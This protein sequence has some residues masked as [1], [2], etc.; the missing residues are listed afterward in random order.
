MI[1]TN[2]DGTGELAPLGG[3]FVR[4]E[5]SLVSTQQPLGRYT[6]CTFANTVSLS[7]FNTIGGT[8]FAKRN[9]FGIGEKVSGR[10]GKEDARM[11]TTTKMKNVMG[12]ITCFQ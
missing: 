5:A 8:H 3:S 7:N 4:G 1:E 12:I 9:D 2:C 10:R 11:K 6:H